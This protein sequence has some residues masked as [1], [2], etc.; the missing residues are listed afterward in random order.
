MKVVFSVFIFVL[1]VCSQQPLMAYKSAHAIVVS[2]HAKEKFVLFG[3][4]GKSK[5]LSTFGG[6]RD[7][8]EPEPKITAAREIFEESLGVLG[9][10]KQLLVL[11]SNAKMVSDPNAEHITYVLPPKFYGSHIPT[12][13]R[14]IRFSKN[15]NLPYSQREMVDIVAVRVKDLRQKML[16]GGHVTFPDN[17]GI[18]RELRECAKGSLYSAII[19]DQ[20]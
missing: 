1:M 15:V 17:E 4:M 7:P 20:L 18:Q 8:G 10:Q 13:F 6:L 16:A 2:L 19:N 11:L 5:K 14:E 12:K 3:L 9:N